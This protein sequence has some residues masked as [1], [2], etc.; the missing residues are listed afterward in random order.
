M[1]NRRPDLIVTVAVLSLAY[2]SAAAGQAR[3]DPPQITLVQALRS[4]HDDAPTVAAASASLA[5]RQA[6]RGVA[7]AAYFPALT[8][9]GSGGYAY[10]NRLVLP[11]APRID[12]ESLTAQA[13]AALEWTALDFTRGARSD[14]IEAAARA[15]TFAVAA[16]RADAMRLAAERFVQAAAA[17]ALVR[18]A[19]LALARRRELQQGVA[20]LVGAGT[21]SPLDLERA[22]IE[23]VS[24]RYTLAAARRDELAACAALAAAL[25]R[26]AAQPVCARADGIGVLERGLRPARALASAGARRRELRAREARVSSRRQEHAAAIAARLPTLGVAA[27]AELSYLDVREGAGIDGYQYGASALLYVRW[28]G[29][30]PVVWTQAG[31]AEAGV[32]LA[33]REWAVERQAVASEAV[34]ASHAIVRAK[35]EVDRAKAVL[36]GAEVARDAQNGRYRAGVTSLLELLDAENLAL[37]ARRARIEAEREHRVAGARLLWASGRLADLAPSQADRVD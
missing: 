33:E 3:P 13:T 28:S 21:R 36:K 14:A 34:A 29:L 12:S 31:V 18:A 25:G 17:S 35:I 8:V 27:A 5:L 30:D 7:S 11:G 4:A 10:D 22:K 2:V 24:A 26:S 9:R 20:E 37:Q 6:E 1:R 19:E 32:A 23:T 15:E 16:T